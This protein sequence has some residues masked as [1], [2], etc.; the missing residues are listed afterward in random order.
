MKMRRRLMMNLVASDSLC[1]APPVG[2]AR[3][4]SLRMTKSPTIY[5]TATCIY[6]T[7]TKPRILFFRENNL[8]CEL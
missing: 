2:N 5:L 4:G 6:Y 1:P 8:V 7:T 3:G